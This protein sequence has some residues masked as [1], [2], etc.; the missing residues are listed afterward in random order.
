MFVA[1]VLTV[2]ALIASRSRIEAAGM[3]ENKN[4]RAK[5]FK[6][7]INSIVL[8]VL[9]VVLQTPISITFFVDIP[10]ANEKTKFVIL[11]SVIYS[12]NYVMPF[13]A[14]FISNSLFRSEII[15]ILDFKAYLKSKIGRN[16]KL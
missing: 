14:Y 4:R 15:K 6:F 3:R 2:R 11:S 13:F 8:N 9:F 16:R 5:Y 7:A 12:I 10:D 1:S